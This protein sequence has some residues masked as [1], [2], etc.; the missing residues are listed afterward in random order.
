VPPQITEHPILQVFAAIRRIDNGV[1]NAIAEFLPKSLNVSEYEVLRHLQIS[2]DGLSP[3]E[4]ALALQAAKSGLTVVLQR[5]SRD[6]LV[7][8]EPCGQDGRRKRVWITENGRE[9]FDEAAHCIRPHM[10]RLREAFTLDEF[11]EVLPFLKALGAWLEARDWEA[12]G[13]AQDEP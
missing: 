8:I 11:R 2:R 12:P 1:Y 7:R 6:G 9:A 5:L 10:H 3:T 4:L 13:A